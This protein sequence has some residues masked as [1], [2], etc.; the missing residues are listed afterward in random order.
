[1][2]CINHCKVRQLLNFSCLSLVLT[3]YRCAC[4]IFCSNTSRVFILHYELLEVALCSWEQQAHG[5]SLLV[6]LQSVPYVCWVR[7][8]LFWAVIRVTEEYKGYG[9][10]W[11]QWAQ[12]GACGPDA[13]KVGL[14]CNRHHDMLSLFFECMHLSLGE[15][16]YCDSS[17]NVLFK[18]FKV[19]C[20]AC[21]GS[22]VLWFYHIF[23]VHDIMVNNMFFCTCNVILPMFILALCYYHNIMCN[24]RLYEG[25]YQVPRCMK[26]YIFVLKSFSHFTS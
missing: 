2:R 26:V 17:Y 7:Q 13:V 14:L 8:H 24:I 22:K 1:M 3:C 20:F 15:F 12:E 4:A 18:A 16:A 6:R 23:F 9:S 11:P 25:G 5:L 21:C 10:P 19:C